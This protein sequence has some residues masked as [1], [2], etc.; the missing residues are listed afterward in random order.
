MPRFE[1]T[2]SLGQVLLA[3][4]FV[5][6]GAAATLGF[7]YG[8]RGDVAIL[9]YQLE[10]N[11]KNDE[12]RAQAAVGFRNEVIDELRGIKDEIIRLRIEMQEKEPRKR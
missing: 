1:P 11:E 9:R 2:F 12:A 3:L 6:S 8:T 5:V 4:S 10:F 7:V